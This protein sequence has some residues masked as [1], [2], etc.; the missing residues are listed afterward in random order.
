MH[1]AQK[2]AISLHRVAFPKL[3]FPTTSPLLEYCCST[4]AYSQLAV[5]Q[6]RLLSG[7]L[8]TAASVRIADEAVGADFH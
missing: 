8:G 3:I 4:N 6:G 2:N 1:H 5:L 7:T